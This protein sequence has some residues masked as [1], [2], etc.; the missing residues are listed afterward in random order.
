MN[1]WAG[2]SHIKFL[3][4][5]FRLFQHRLPIS[6]ESFGK[7]RLVIG[8][9]GDVVCQIIG[10]NKAVFVSVFGHMAKAVFKQVAGVLQGDGLPVEEDSAALRPAQACQYLGQL[11][12]A[13]ALHPRN[14]QN[15]ACP[16]F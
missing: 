3:N 11:G 7:G 12:L 4:Q 13:V 14:A 8:A 5:F 10:E 2:G 1:K 16:H 9:E 15:F 6:L